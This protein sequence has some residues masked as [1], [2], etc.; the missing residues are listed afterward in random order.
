MTKASSRISLSRDFRTSPRQ[1][2]HPRLA[3]I[4]VIASSF[5]Q[6]DASADLFSYTRPASGLYRWILGQGFF[7]AKAVRFGGWR[8]EGCH[9]LSQH[10]KCT[11][12]TQP[13]ASQ[14]RYPT[15]FPFFLR[16]PHCLY[17]L[18]RPMRLKWNAKL[19]IKYTT[20]SLQLSQIADKLCT[21]MI[22]ALALSCTA[23]NL[24]VRA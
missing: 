2:L 9:P 15:S 21:R 20:K 3:S 18:H 1:Q 24:P 19:K 23:E 14:P 10:K 8:A 16:L 5:N 6:V 17:V 13:I 4:S 7:S 22:L 12:H 11:T